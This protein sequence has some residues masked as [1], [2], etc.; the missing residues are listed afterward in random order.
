MTMLWLRA[1]PRLTLVG[2]LVGL[3]LAALGWLVAGPPGVLAAVVLS[4]LLLLAA[5]WLSEPVL[6]RMSAS[7]IATPE[8][9]P[10]AIE[11][12]TRLAARAGIRSPRVAVSALRAPNA[13]AAATPGGGLVGVTASLLEM[14]NDAELEAVLAHEIAH[15]ARGE[16]AAATIA[17][18]CAALPGWFTKLS[19]SD[20]FYDAAFRRPLYRTWGGR[21][22]RPLRDAIACCN[23]PLAVVLVRTSVSQAAELQADTDAAR[24]TEDPG[25]LASALRKLNALAGRVATPVNP[26]LS[27]LLVMHPFGNQPL[28]RLFDTHPPLT[29]RL[30]TIARLPVRSPDATA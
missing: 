25:A 3:P 2:A 30:D 7:T 11:V 14:L 10:E 1:V 26:A 4:G 27:H 15:L 28:G 18:V 24:M 21:R 20:L 13:Y 16:G 23:V 9:Q 22:L 17:A 8:N 5:W 12:V 6:L 29:V 19:G